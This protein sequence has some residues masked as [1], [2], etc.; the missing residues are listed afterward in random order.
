MAPVTW[1]F[2]IERDIEPINSKRTIRNFFY[3]TNTKI[4]HCREYAHTALKTHKLTHSQMFYIF[5]GIS[6]KVWFPFVP[7]IDR[8]VTTSQ[9]L[10]QGLN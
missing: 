7:S 5:L 3:E 4:M 10:R 8:V 2:R 6:I 9:N 1:T